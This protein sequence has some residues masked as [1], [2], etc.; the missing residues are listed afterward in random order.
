MPRNLIDI[1]MLVAVMF[2]ISNG[3]VVGVMYSIMFNDK[4][5]IERV[6]EATLVGL[7]VTFLAF[8]AIVLAMI[9]IT[10]AAK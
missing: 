2:S 7:G 9:I 5:I 10:G 8:W 1:L 3:I 6:I 4:P